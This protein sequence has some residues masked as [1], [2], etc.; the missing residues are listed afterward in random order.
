MMRKLPNKIVYSLIFI[1][2]VSSS[3]IMLLLSIDGFHSAVF[4]LTTYDACS[5]IGTLLG[6]PSHQFRLC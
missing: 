1:F 5:T 3:K 6:T 4:S 2:E